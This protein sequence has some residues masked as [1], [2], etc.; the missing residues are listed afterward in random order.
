MWHMKGLRVIAGLL[1]SALFLYLALRGVDFRRVGE[2][3]RHA[4][5]WWLLPGV[6][7]I[8]LSI[9]LRAVRWRLLF[10][11]RTGLR[12]AS[13]FGSLNVGYLVNDLL[14]M[15]LGE[16]VRA[17]LISQQ[18]AVSATHALSTVAV[19]RVLDMVVTVAYLAVLIPFVELPVGAA[20]KVQA[21]AAVAVGALL[22]ML[23]AG[24]LPARTHQLAR[25]GTRF[26]PPGPARRLH[27]LM[28]HFLEGFAVLS[29][30][31]VALPVVALSVA[32]WAL[33]ALALYCVL[34]AF[35]LRLSPAAPFFVLALVSLSFVVPAAPGHIGVF[36]WTVITALATFHV[37]E[38][39]A[40][41]YAF[42]AHLVAFVPPM[43]MGAAYLWRA[44]LSWERVLAFR[45]A[46][47][48][49]GAGGEAPEP[50]GASTASA[51]PGK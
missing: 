12:F 3:L 48:R 26:L 25:L 36:H 33:A 28:D 18:E 6:L 34:F 5:Y 37:Q 38:D 47:H 30:P 16:V 10:H 39:I 46:P 4:N 22:V 14:P 40:R 21:V 11:P 27:G 41:S 7:A 17:Y 43:L 20:D 42:L 45:R 35:D 44:G 9:L 32:L 15:R 23:V 51:R 31:R 24:A 19:E 1:V 8:V 29:A 49:T 13:V 2:A 50:A